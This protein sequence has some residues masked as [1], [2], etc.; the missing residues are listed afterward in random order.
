VTN[1]A[2]RLCQIGMNDDRDLLLSFRA[3]TD[4]WAD[5]ARAEAKAVRLALAEGPGG[6]AAA[7]A[8][9][10][11][12][13]SIVEFIRSANSCTADAL[14]VMKKRNVKCRSARKASLTPTGWSRRIADAAKAGALDASIGRRSGPAGIAREGAESARSRN[15]GSPAV[16]PGPWP[17]CPCCQCGATAI[18]GSKRKCMSQPEQTSEVQPSGEAVHL[19]SLSSRKLLDWKEMR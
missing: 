5:R 7:A 9:S 17:I 2:D 10:R 4:R 12:L 19:L 15:S 18:R 3:K 1:C 13:F 8:A 11:R 14:P 6:S 16:P